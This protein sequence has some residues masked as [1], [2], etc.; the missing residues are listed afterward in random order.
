[1]GMARQTLPTPPPPEHHSRII[2]RTV[3]GAGVKRETFIHLETFE[4]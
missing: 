1:M 3:N 4:L 2:S